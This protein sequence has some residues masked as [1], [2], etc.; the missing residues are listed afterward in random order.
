MRT[1]LAVHNHVC[2][3]EK[4]GKGLSL[5]IIWGAVAISSGLAGWSTCSS[6]FLEGGHG[7]LQGKKSGILYYSSNCL[8]RLL[9]GV[10]PYLCGRLVNDCEWLKV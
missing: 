3:F 1:Q 2:M 4:T 10:V 9:C 5:D 7:N 6:T 8:V